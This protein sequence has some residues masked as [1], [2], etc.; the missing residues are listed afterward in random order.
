LFTFEG[1]GLPVGT[2]EVEMIERA[3]ER[4]AFEASLPPFTDEASFE[5]RRKL[6]EDM[7]MRDWEYREAQIKK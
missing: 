7:E 2:D 3:R 5:E 6:L 4:R 1:K